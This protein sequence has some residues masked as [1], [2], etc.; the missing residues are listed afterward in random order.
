[1][2]TRPGTDQGQGYRHMQE[3]VDGKE[4]DGEPQQEQALVHQFFVGDLVLLL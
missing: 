4:Q 2:A 3:P 1:M